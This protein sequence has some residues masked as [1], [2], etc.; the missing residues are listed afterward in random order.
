M[1]RIPGCSPTKRWNRKNYYCRPQ[2]ESLVPVYHKANVIGLQTFFRDKFAIWESNGR[3]V[4]EA[5]NNFKN[6]IFE[7]IERF[8]PHKILRKNSDPEYYNK[9]VKKLKLKIRRAHNIRKLG[10]KYREELKRLSKQLLL[11]KKKM[12]RRHF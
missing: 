10:Q 1:S 8:I 9:E 4:E 12:H 2:V 5:W 7:S 6:I 11:D 3:F